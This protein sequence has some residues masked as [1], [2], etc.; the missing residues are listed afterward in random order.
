V[1]AGGSDKS[2]GI[3]VARLAGIPRRVIDRARRILAGLESQALVLDR[4]NGDGL[5]RATGERRAT[6]RRGAEARASGEPVARQL[7]LFASPNDALLRELRELDTD[8]LTPLEALQILAELKRRL[9]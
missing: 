1:V 5:A 7:D 2:Y 3:H 9:V 4:E 8:R 6:P